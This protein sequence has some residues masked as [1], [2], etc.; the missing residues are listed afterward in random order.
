MLQHEKPCEI[1]RP[2]QMKRP[3]LLMLFVGVLAACEAPPR[4]PQAEAPPAPAPEPVPPPTA[5]A[6]AP[7]V[8][9]PPASPEGKQQ[10]QKLAL[11]AAD[12]LQSGNEDGARA[13]LKR[14]LTLDW[15]NKL[16]LSLSRQ[17]TADPMTTLGR[18]N[19][20]YTVRPGDTLAVLAQ[21]QLGDAYLFYLLA[22]Y[23][24]L[25]VPKQLS[26]GQVIRLPGKA[27]VMREPSPPS[28]S[29]M[30]TVPTPR[31]TPPV[32]TPPS[33]PPTAPPQPP[34]PPPP[35]PP[36]PM[37]PGEQAMRDGTAAERAND[38]PRALSAYRKAD[39][40][41]QAGAAVKADQTRTLLV[42]RHTLAARNAFTKQDLD[43]AIANWQRVIDL[44]AN[45]GTAH[46]EL[47]RSK[48]LKKK[49]TDVPK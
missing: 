35:P 36:A 19:F 29:S 9:G 8:A 24:D 15:Q 1:T 17:M 39:S 37:T 27:S 16:A 41:G 20:A 28:A 22:R 21:R 13:E 45:N 33:S 49:L 30:P 26:S 47:E 7:V 46:S 25:K 38:L 42:G 44:D 32:A 6:P 43:G 2:T 18:E 3:L 14:A 10:A 23:N 4:V 40:L 12:L 11:A 34:A 48:T 5:P 31:M